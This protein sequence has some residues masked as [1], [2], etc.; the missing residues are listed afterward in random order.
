MA[1]CNCIQT[2]KKGIVI[3][4]SNV[5]FRWLKDTFMVVP[6]E[7]ERIARHLLVKSG[8]LCYMLLGVL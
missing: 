3:E 4:T 1:L 2:S 5:S 6:G 8:C 7:L